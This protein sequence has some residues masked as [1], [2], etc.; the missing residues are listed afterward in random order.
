MSRI[1]KFVMGFF[2]EYRFL[3][4]FHLCPVKWNGVTFPSTEHLYQWLKCEDD[5]WLPQFLSASPSESKHLGR[6][7]PLME[8]FDEKKVG[9]MYA[10]NL[11]KYKQN[12]ELKDLLLATQDKH[13]VEWNYWGDRFWGMITTNDNKLVGDNNLGRVLMEV[14]TKLKYGV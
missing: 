4:N 14:R 11:E 8:G 9:I 3:S 10:I 5:E 1:N 13:L 6:K 7:V 2:D 12:P